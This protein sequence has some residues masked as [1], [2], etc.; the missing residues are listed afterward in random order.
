MITIGTK[1][2][3][4][5]AHP[6]SDFYYTLDARQIFYAGRYILDY[7]LA[8]S[9]STISAALIYH[10]RVDGIIDKPLRRGTS[11]FLNGIISALHF[12]ATTV[13]RSR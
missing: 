9:C 10:R 11:R 13:F 1:R 2:A 12:L 3:F 7:R 5:H 8:R 4:H 6:I